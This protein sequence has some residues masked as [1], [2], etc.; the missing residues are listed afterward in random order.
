MSY[1]KLT[2]HFLLVIGLA[3][4]TFSQKS[5]ANLTVGVAIN[6]L[7]NPFFLQ[8][9][10]GAKRKADELTNGTA[11]ILVVASDYSLD[12]QRWQLA[13]LVERNADIVVITAA[14]QQALAPEIKK[15]IKQGTQVIAVDVSAAGVVATV[16]TD[17]VKAG[18]QAC[19][20]LINQL[21]GVGKIAI[22]NGP[23]VSAVV[24]RVDGCNQA[25]AGAS[26]IQ[27]LQIEAQGQGSQAGGEQAMKAILAT[28]P[29]VN[30]VFAIND[31]SAIGAELEAQ[32]R[33][34]RDIVI[35]SVDGAPI[36][37]QALKNSNALV[38]A[39][40]AQYPDLMAE[41]AVE[42]GYQLKQG[43]KLSQQVFLIDPSLVNKNNVMQYKGWAE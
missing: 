30:G 12:R 37:Q 25:I 27:L 9:V 6:D 20:H 29:D 8:I 24:D 26:G 34:K 31:P 35:T 28:Y 11:N 36:M 2:I 4:F 13:Q 14:D 39:T 40:A 33:G 17:N 19:T 32:N 41:K 3:I 18:F 10:K 16:A 23:N 21:G 1:K 42:L 43:Q 15:A 22:I 7:N 38:S 5:L